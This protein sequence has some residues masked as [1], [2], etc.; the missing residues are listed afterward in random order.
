MFL[1][2]NE[3]KIERQRSKFMC[4]RLIILLAE[5]TGNGCTYTYG[6]AI[7]I[8]QIFL[9]SDLTIESMNIIRNVLILNR[10]T[11]SNQRHNIYPEA[12]FQVI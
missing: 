4:K 2:K 5:V 3:N 10:N 12:A 1:H 7:E 11:K 6:Y 8:L 9:K